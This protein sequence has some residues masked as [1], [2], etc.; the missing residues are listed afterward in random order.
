MSCIP[1]IKK[2][3][4]DILKIILNYKKEID[5][6]KY[7]KS[8]IIKHFKYNFYRYIEYN[9]FTNSMY[10]DYNVFTLNSN[11]MKKDI[12]THICLECGNYTYITYKPENICCECVSNLF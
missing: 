8:K 6:H 9:N 5:I 3:P 12:K 10:I 2:T 1:F 11:P 4:T 7:K